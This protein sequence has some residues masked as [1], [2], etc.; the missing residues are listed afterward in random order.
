L[1]VIL[2]GDP[3][4]HAAARRWAASLAENA[5]V[6]T[7]LWTLPEAAHNLI[8]AA[9]RGAPRRNELALVALGAPRQAEARRR[10]DAVLETLA[11][12]GIVPLFVDEPHA[13]PWVE[14]IGLAYFGDWVSVHLAQRLGVD[15]AP[16]HL[17]DEVKLRLASGKETAS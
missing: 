2:S 14:A 11:E 4:R 8:M 10:W 5:K 7:L 12:H 9:G 3:G 13:E 1:P 15:P 16:I 6:S 17:M